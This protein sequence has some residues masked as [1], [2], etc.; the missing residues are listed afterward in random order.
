MNRSLL[1]GFYRQYIRPKER[2]DVSLPAASVLFGIIGAL[3]IAWFPG[4]WQGMLWLGLAGSLLALAAFA[5]SKALERLP[6]T[7][8]NLKGMVRHIDGHSLRFLTWFTGHNL[9]WI[10]LGN[11]V[12][13][14]LIHFFD[15]D[16]WVLL[17][18]AG[19]LAYTFYALCG[20]FLLPPLLKTNPALCWLGDAP[21]NISNLFER[22]SATA[23]LR[24][25]WAAN[26]RNRDDLA[27]IR[28][29]IVGLRQDNRA[30]N[31]LDPSYRL[32]SGLNR[33]LPFW[34]EFRN[35][36]Y[37]FAGLFVAAFCLYSLLL[38]LSIGW[39]NYAGEQPSWLIAAIGG[40]SSANP[41][42][43]IVVVPDDWAETELDDN[44][45]SQL[46]NELAVDDNKNG[47]GSGDQNSQS[48]EGDSQEPGHDEDGGSDPQ[49][50]NGAENGDTDGNGNDTGDKGESGNGE[51]GTANGAEDGNGEGG[52]DET[53]SG[54]TD[55]ETEGGDN[56]PMD[57]NSSG[58][59]V[60]EGDNGSGEPGNQD[61]SS[62]DSQSPPESHNNG[63]EEGNET[64]QNGQSIGDGEQGEEQ[65]GEEGPD[66]GQN[67]GAGG[68]ADQDSAAEE[69]SGDGENGQGSDAN[70]ESGGEITEDQEE[71]G[72]GADSGDQNT[73]N[74][75]DRDPQLGQPEDVSSPIRPADQMFALEIPALQPVLGS[76][77]VDEE[78]PESELVAPTSPFTEVEQSDN[79]N[80]LTKPVQQIPGWMR[81]IFRQLLSR[82]R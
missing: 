50:A 36:L 26:M 10:A 12:G 9:L 32:I 47:D 60:G 14:L 80:S 53:S 16:W 52:G 8:K 79:L 49:Q 22:M 65:N 6:D 7:P 40:L 31:I 63:D 59:D 58:G 51:Q 38:M 45:H 37:A 55:G 76:G 29:R 19:I 73:L 72:T 66:N 11:L 77:T 54:Q 44:E 18:V 15:R 20:L 2:W 33:K 3:I 48:G 61:N 43:E 68:E 70:G 25:R 71:T 78:R 39:P 57:D 17:C 46:I 62:G 69:E 67:S 4:V 24:E 41:E 30:A 5:F 23:V 82:W 35:R 56:Q 64:G 34:Q 74:Q 81:A 75:P 28:S 21:G 42:P 27:K 13:T 1:E